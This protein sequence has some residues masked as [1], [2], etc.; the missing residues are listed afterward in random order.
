MSSFAA[1]WF[2]L[3]GLSG[4]YVG[5][6]IAVANFVAVTISFGAIDFVKDPTAS[7][8][9]FRGAGAGGD[10]QRDPG[11]CSLHAEATAD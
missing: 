2:S 11:E 9:A 6:V 3:R 1:L 4:L 10:R 8:A 7:V 5:G